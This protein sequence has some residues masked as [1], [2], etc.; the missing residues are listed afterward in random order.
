M[1]VKKKL[2]I[3]LV[4]ALFITILGGCSKSNSKNLKDKKVLNIGIMQIVEHP[5]LDLAR[6]G[7]V[8]TLAK[9]GFKDGEKVKLDVQNAQGDM[10]TIQTIAKN[11]TSHKKDM[12]FAIATPSAQAAYN[13]TKKTPIAITAVTDPKEAKLVKSLEKSGTNVFGTSDKIS[14]DENFD[15]IKKILPG[16]KKIGILYNTS[17]KNSEIQVKDAEKAAKKFGFEIVKQGITNVNDIHQSLA[18]ILGKV[19]VMFIPTDNTVASAMPFISN[20]CNKKK[21]A[22]IG[23]EEAHVKAGALA[24]S[25]IDYYKLGAK[26]AEMAI[27]VINGKDPKETKIEFMKETELVINEKAVEKLGI[28]IPKDLENKAKKVK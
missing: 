4:V 11:F 15:L 2:S 19:D 24:T 16:K 1:V 8:E 26:T 7:F 9:N 25:G 5:A 17:E 12:I 23:S 21:I 13:S 18:S 14:V 27:D 10:A 20:E 22:I 6:K 28:K 3:L